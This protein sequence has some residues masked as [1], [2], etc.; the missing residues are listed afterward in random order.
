MQKQQ[1]YNILWRYAKI[2]GVV[3]QN[4][5][6]KFWVSHAGREFECFGK[7][8]LKTSKICV[9]DMVEIC[10]VDGAFQISKQYPRHNFLIR[11]P[12]ANIDKLFIVVCAVPEPDFFVVD[13]MLLFAYV[14][15][16][17]P[18][19]LVNKVDE[20]GFDLFEN[21]K[22]V[23]QNVCQIFCVSARSGYNINVLKE[24]MHSSICAFAGQ[25]AVGKS[26]LVNSLVPMLSQKVGEISQKIERGKNTTT[27]CKL[28]EVEEDTYIIDTPGFS[29]IDEY[30]LPIKYDELSSFYPDFLQYA[31]GCKFKN[32]CDHI[33]ERQSD[34]MVKQKV[35]DGEIDVGRYERYKQIYEGLKMRWKNEHR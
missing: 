35:V 6:D 5:S 18:I 34:C 12:V 22:S 33:N 13:K 8:N 14:N 2:K 3:T 24:A 16:I 11:P 20:F 28:C 10:E 25:S 31:D 23:Y 17:E 21:L 26:S 15:G 1:T 27:H 7:K 19:I 4:I 32:T 9:G 30:Y 29:L